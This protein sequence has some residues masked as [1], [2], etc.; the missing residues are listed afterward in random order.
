M[1]HW[2]LWPSLHLKHST[3]HPYPWCSDYLATLE[4]F[5]LY[6]QVTSSHCVKAWFFSSSIAPPALAKYRAPQRE[7]I[8]QSLWEHLAE[9]S[10]ISKPVIINLWCVVY[11]T[12]CV[13]I[14]VLWTGT[15]ISDCGCRFKY[16]FLQWTAAQQRERLGIVQETKFDLY[17]SAHMC[18]SRY[19]GSSW[20][21]EKAWMILLTVS[22]EF[23]HQ[24]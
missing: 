19:L 11:H 23:P 10:G 14:A 24:I 9:C 5:S 21:K 20:G 17:P 3:L 8:M 7:S 18:K 15:Q 2:L 6:L 22:Q 16:F 4:E 13:G 12:P 1:P